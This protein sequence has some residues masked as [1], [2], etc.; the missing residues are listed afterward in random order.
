MATDIKD[1]RFSIYINNDAARKSLIEMEQ[2][3][4]KYT[5][6]LRNLSEAGKAN[7]A[8]YKETKAKLDQVKQSMVEMSRQAGINSLSLKQLTSLRQALNAEYA[9]AIPGTAHWQKLKNDLDQV[10]RKQTE[11][12]IQNNQTGLSLG[13]LAEGANRYIGLITMA[14]ASVTGLVLG[15]RKTIDA[16][17]E[18]DDKLSDVMKTTG[19]T[20]EEVVAL[21]GE[22]G[23]INTRTSQME[24]L[25]L[26]RVAGKLGI[27]AKEDVA[28]FVRASNQI[29]VALTEDLGG[30]VEESINQ[31]GKLVEIFK[32]KGRFGIEGALLKVG[33]AIN[34]L[35]AAS[36]ANEGYLVEFAK[37]VAGVAPQA[38]ISLTKILGLGAT[39]DQLGQSSE[40]ASTVFAAVVPDMFKDTGKYAQIAGLSVKDF[41]KLLGRDANAAFIAFLKGLNGNN[42]GLAEMATKLD[43]LGL[44]GKRS[45]SVLG[46]LAAN[47]S[48]LQQQQALANEEFVKGT[49]IT[50]EYNTKNNNAQAQLEKARKSFQAMAVEL[51]EKLAP[52]MTFSTNGLSYF[53]KAL[54]I[55]IEFVGEHKRIIAA[56]VI[57]LI[58]YTTVV[59]ALALAESIRNKTGALSIAMTKAKMVAENT[60]IVVTQAYAA[61]TM[62][63]TG[64]VKGATQAIRVLNTAIKGSGWGWLVA[65]IAGVISYL[66][67]FRE[68]TDKAAKFTEYYNDAL[69]RNTEMLVKEKTETEGLIR[70]AMAAD[71]RTERRKKLIEELIQ[72]YPDYIGFVNA[73][74]VSNSELAKVLEKINQAYAE[75]FKLMRVNARMEALQKQYADKELEKMKAEEEL[76]KYRNMAITEGSDEAK[77][78]KRL[79]DQINLIEQQQKLIEGNMSLMQTRASQIKQQ[80]EEIENPSNAALEAK[81]NDYEKAYKMQLARAEKARKEG[82]EADAEFYEKAAYEWD[83]KRMDAKSTLDQRKL[84]E[85]E[86]AKNKRKGG[87]TE[88]EILD[89][90]V[91][92]TTVGSDSSNARGRQMGMV[93]TGKNRH[94]SPEKFREEYDA[95]LE[96]TIDEE[97]SNAD[98]EARKD[99]QKIGIDVNKA[100]GD[101]ADDLRKQGASDSDAL[102]DRTR[103]DME[104]QHSQKVN[105]IN[106]N[107]NTTDDDK[108][109]QLYNAER[110]HLE[111]MRVLYEAYGK[112]ITDIDRQLA[113][114]KTAYNEAM[115]KAALE[116]SAAEVKAGYESGQAAVENAETVE[117][118]VGNVLNSVR[119]A[120]KAK[121][122]EGLAIQLVNVLSSV[123]FPFNFAVA[124]AAGAAF[125]ALFDSIVPQFAEG[126]YPVVGA[127]DGRRYNA[128]YRSHATSGLYTRPT[129]IGG[130]GLVGERGSEIV[131]S[132]PH[133]K[134]LQMNYP[135][136]IR[137]IYSTA[138]R[139]PQ[140]AGGNYP[141]Q[142][143]AATGAQ[144]DSKASGKEDM[145]IELMAQMV[146]ELQKPTRAYIPYN[147][148]NDALNEVDG[149]E[150]GLE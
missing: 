108:N 23:K 105:R 81:I 149:I 113:E 70:Q 13:K 98:A 26:A 71:A 109:T 106:S 78:E 34:S 61:V 92:E 67:L 72:K 55:T 32:L 150:K 49:S 84:A 129:L 76:S 12:R 27:N 62:L 43:G 63:L 52:A 126:N 36:T 15:I 28:G 97:I 123:P 101:T 79:K 91:N 48:L 104:S 122:A 135:E 9:K 8:E 45:I 120:I 141:A 66:V 87:T 128:Q 11:L 73:E 14:A 47:T 64:N 117:E 44:E 24:L 88:I 137:T 134:H 90:P 118:A 39:L 35:G 46:V 10:I 85:E 40:V 132:N 107:P 51:G 110:D 33:S 148:L 116:R 124:A 100:F 2:L 68:E 1:F 31:L 93:G 22:L 127:T 144:K 57:S 142:G 103:G 89:T 94:F 25:D 19:M 143:G 147:D 83:M 74:M 16:Y 95:W 3:S 69:E 5:D 82:K 136:V 138:T 59:Q 140:F 17:A 125:S 133:V 139:V 7:T 119:N 29:K 99:L 77:E 65:A 115:K 37:R 30:N 131:I 145:M 96:K 112:D 21:N 58:A 42:G 146:K 130:L 4:A 54:K 38:D 111:A 80:I 75:K 50:Q 41:S 56:S 53:L 20:K 114:A 6:T 102:F 86:K 121:L 18:W 60:G